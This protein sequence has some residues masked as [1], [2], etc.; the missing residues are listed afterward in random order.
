MPT[1]ELDRIGDVSV[2]T[3]FS[4]CHYCPVVFE[5]V[6]QFAGDDDEVEKKRMWSK[7]DHARFFASTLAV[8]WLFEFDGRPIND[9]VYLV[10]VL[11]ALVDRFVPVS[12]QTY[13]A[14]WMKSPPR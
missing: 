8:Y 1:T 6:L 12:S 11:L 5:C 10:E 9:F 13:V 4:R 14:V 7:E 3:P 2:L